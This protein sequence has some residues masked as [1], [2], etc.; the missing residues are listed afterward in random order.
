MAANGNIDMEVKVEQGRGYQSV[1]GRK[2]A[3]EQ[4][5]IGSIQ[6]D[7]SFHLL[8]VLALKLKQLALNKEQI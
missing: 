6:L 5:K 1:A 7:S 2:A 8:A 4:T 3:K